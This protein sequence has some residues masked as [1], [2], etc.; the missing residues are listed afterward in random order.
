MSAA[1][2]REEA[3]VVALRS[4]VVRG[5]QIE[6]GR[7]FSAWVVNASGA[8]A[9]RHLFGVGGDDRR[10]SCRVNTDRHRGVGPCL[11]R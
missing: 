9:S 10:V 7:L 5:V 4:L 8:L 1:C 6:R 2:R 3:G 11:G